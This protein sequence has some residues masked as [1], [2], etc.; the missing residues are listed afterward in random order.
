M[1]N[2]TVRP[3]MNKMVFDELI[4]IYPDKEE[5]LN[6]SVSAFLLL[7][8]LSI[9]EL[10]GIFNRQELIGIVASFN[11]TMIDFSISIPPLEMLRVQMEDAIDLENND[12]MYQYDATQMLSK[13]ARMDNL[14]AMFLLEEVH[15][16]WNILDGHKLETFLE[17][18]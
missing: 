10:K 12:S 17:K 16:F 7:R 11:G 3:Y 2:D 13:I 18:Y 8:K 15:R 9:R 4:T 5:G 1:A 6:R 14:K